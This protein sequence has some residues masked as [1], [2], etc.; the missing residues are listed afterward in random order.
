MQADNKTLCSIEDLPH[1]PLLPIFK[2]SLALIGGKG[3]ASNLVRLEKEYGSI[4]QLIFPRQ[5]I[6]YTSSKEVLEEIADATRFGRLMTPG[7]EEFREVFGYSLPFASDDEPTWVKSQQ[8]LSPAFGKKAMINYFST[9]IETTENLLA[10]WHNIPEDTVFDAFQD[11]KNVSFEVLSICGFTYHPHAFS[12]PKQHPFIK[13]MEEIVGQIL[14]RSFLPPL[15]KNL[16]WRENSKYK[17]NKEFTANF[18]QQILEDR[19]AHPEK[20]AGKLDFLNLMLA[21]VDSNGDKMDETEIRYN[22]LAFFFVGHKTSSI[23]LSFTLYLILSHPEV[24]RKAYEEIDRVLGTNPNNTLSFDQLPQLSYME[25]IIKESLRYY[26][27]IP[28]FARNALKDGVLANKYEI[29]RGQYIQFIMESLHRNRELWGEDAD[30]F[31]PDHF[32]PE[33]VEK[34]DP[35]A[36]IPFGIGHRSCLGQ[37]FVQQLAKITLTLILHKFNVKLKDGFKIKIQELVA[38]QPENVLIQISKREDSNPVAFVTVPQEFKK[39]QPGSETQPQSKAQEPQSSQPSA[40]VPSLSKESKGVETKEGSHGTP[41]LILFGSNLG[42][43]EEFA[44]RLYQQA[45][46]KGFAAQVFPLDECVD[47]LPG[48]GGVLIVTATYNGFP[49]DNAI[50]FSTWL[51]KNTHPADLLKGVRYGIFGFGNTDWQQ[52]FQSYPRYIN[53]RLKEL[54][55]TPIYD[56]GEADTKGNYDEPLNKWATDLWPKL[57]SEFNIH[58]KLSS[59]VDKPIF[60]VEVVTSPEKKTYT[61]YHQVG[62]VDL[63]ILANRELETSN[64]P[65]EKKKSIRHLEFKLPEPMTYICGD[66]L[67]VFPRHSVDLVQKA[68]NRFKLTSETYVK[69]TTTINSAQLHL[70]VHEPIAVVDLFAKYFDLQRIASRSTIQALAQYAQEPKEKEKLQQMAHDD[71]ES[72]LLYLEEVYDNRKSILDLLYD[73]P[74]CDLPLATYLSMMPQ[75]KPRLYSISSSPLDNPNVCSLTV[76]VIREPAH[77]GVGIFK[78]VSS[79]YLAGVVQGSYIRGCVTAPQSHFRLPTS[80]STPIIMICAGTGF[81][82]FRGFLKEREAWVRD[83]DHIGEAL[84]FFGCRH[85]DKDYLYKDELEEMSRKGIL[86]V[87]PAFSRL[88]GKGKYYVQDSIWDNRD[89]FWEFMHKNGVAY[90]CGDGERMVP[91]VR[92]KIIKIYQEKTGESAEHGEEWLSELTNKGKYIVDMWGG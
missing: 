24:L 2:N 63:E 82:P 43:S 64:D 80:R 26:S 87:F 27:P 54:G 34:R 69:L 57:F 65:E 68:I 37:R 74:S 38:L 41:L 92:K 7:A 32:S 61:P 40:P 3:W 21:N 1:P 88:E 8:I 67:R 31:N 47:R 14:L 5:R 59:F 50:N 35:H 48:I 91:G 53:N 90:I 10:K 51:R 39:V 16:R 77:S 33:Q 78:G 25:Q 17:K 19:R 85:P 79:N 62:E 56:I 22:L 13:A 66:Y 36:F 12:L 9:M 75:L 18:V 71:E 29:K 84:L 15:I 58:Q 83:G 30:Q 60:E 23:L 46:N 81:A 42:M 55:A 70:P 86:R 20:Y 72:R 44:Q 49:P 11:M 6:I 4:F 45:T 52:T 28:V 89:A 73:Y 76:G